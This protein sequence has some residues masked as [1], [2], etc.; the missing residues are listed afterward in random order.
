MGI[1]KS[2]GALWE[3]KT[4]WVRRVGGT[5]GT[6]RILMIYRLAKNRSDEF[7]KVKSAYLSLK[8]LGDTKWGCSKLIFLFKNHCF[9]PY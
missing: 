2:M 1:K 4:E 9:H 7:P 5:L 8:K 6:P 3:S